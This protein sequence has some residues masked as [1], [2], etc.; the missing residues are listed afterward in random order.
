MAKIRMYFY[1]TGIWNMPGK[2]NLL[3]NREKDIGIYAHNQ[4]ICP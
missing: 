1:V 4:R 2:K 3:L